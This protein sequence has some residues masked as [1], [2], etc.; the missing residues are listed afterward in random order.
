MFPEKS[1]E[2]GESQMIRKAGI[3]RLILMSFLLLLLVFGL[4]L[5]FGAHAAQAATNDNIIFLHH[6][7]GAG[8]WGGGIGVPAWFA[9]YNTVHST[10][11][12]ITERS[13]P[14]SPYDW[15]N[16]P[17]DYWNLWIHGACNSSNPN[18]ECMPK[19][20]TDYDM[21]I[22]K[23]CFPGADV[24][25]D[26][27]DPDVS[28]SIKTL[29]NYKLQYRALRQ[30]MD[31]YPNSKFIVWT[32]ASLRQAETSA[33]NAA[34]A[35]EFVDWVKYSFL[36]EDSRSHPNIFIFDFFGL[37]AG[38]DNFLRDDY[39]NGVDSHPNSLANSTVMPLFSQFIVDTA[40]CSYDGARNTRTSAHSDNIL[41]VYNAAGA[42]DTVQLHTKNFSG[43]LELS[44]PLFITLQGGLGCDYSFNQGY[45]TIT[46][47]LTI[48]G[49]TVTLDRIIVR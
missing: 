28:S 11:Y 6:S 4:I 40:D 22:Y 16:Y 46:G 34:R 13:Y 37:T 47:S 30:M 38:A 43:P 36:T 20:T 49:G 12:A 1:D 10:S 17:Y 29:A 14:N 41:E 2:S 23:H 21:V 5:S 45:S 32:L 9:N 25:A 8:V 33:A 44:N 18:I 48:R 24:V 15:A 42:G 31:S 3:R 19:L 26:E 27:G 39:E 35:R 7:T